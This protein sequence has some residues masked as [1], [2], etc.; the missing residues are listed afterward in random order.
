LYVLPIARA[1]LAGFACRG[2]REQSAR[3]A[4]RMP[5]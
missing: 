3:G 5:A 1:V 2:V 4:T